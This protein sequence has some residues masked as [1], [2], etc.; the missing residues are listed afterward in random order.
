M[1]YSFIAGSE[2]NVLLLTG[3][4]FSFYFEKMAHP[5]FLQGAGHSGLI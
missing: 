1:I 3:D 5:F 2:N 4:Q